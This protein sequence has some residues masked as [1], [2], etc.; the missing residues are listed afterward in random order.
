M[1]KQHYL[2]AA[3]FF[4]IGFLI[5]YLSVPATKTMTVLTP[6]NCFEYEVTIARYEHTLSI[7]QERNP[8]A[9]KQFETIFTEETE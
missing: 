4:V 8:Q 7:L 1:N 6:P 2:I 5:S 9:A 3:F